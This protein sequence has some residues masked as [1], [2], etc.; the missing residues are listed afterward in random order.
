MQYGFI[1]SMTGE[2]LRARVES[3]RARAEWT[4]LRN[5][6]GFR[7]QTRRLEDMMAANN[8]AILT[9][10]TRR[11]IIDYTARTQPHEVFDR[12]TTDAIVRYAS[13]HLFSPQVRAAQQRL[14]RTIMGSALADIRPWGPT[15][16]RIRDVFAEVISRRAAETAHW[17]PDDVDLFRPAKV[18]GLDDKLPADQARNLAGTTHLNDY[19]KALL[20]HS[21]RRSTEPPG[22][23]VTAR[24]RR[25]RGPNTRRT[26]PFLS[27]LAGFARA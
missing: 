19:R 7:K 2:K 8:R 1:M 5:T 13:A 22:K 17:L 23:T 20:H 16:D 3:R 12:E 10:E 6:P 21:Q 9:P 15:L 24:P 14:H 4:Q 27:R 18:T 11:R 25:T 26:T